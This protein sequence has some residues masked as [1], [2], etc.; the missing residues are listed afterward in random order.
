MGKSQSICATDIEPPEAGSGKLFLSHF[1]S[2]YVVVPEVNFAEEMSVQTR[3]NNLYAV[4][5]AT[6]FS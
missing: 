2:D 4:T 5:S 6:D 3:E 1:V